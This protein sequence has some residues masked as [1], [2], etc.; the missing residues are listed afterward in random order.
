MVAV[1][2][3]ALRKKVHGI[4]DLQLSSMQDVFLRRMILSTD[5]GQVERDRGYLDFLLCRLIN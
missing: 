4:I 5:N 3:G 1:V 2:V